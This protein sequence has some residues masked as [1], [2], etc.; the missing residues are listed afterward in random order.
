MRRMAVPVTTRVLARGDLDKIVAQLREIGA[1]YVFIGKGSV[2]MDPEKRKEELELLIKSCDY[3]KKEGF[4]VG[5]WLWS[6]L[7]PGDLPYQRMVGLN[8]VVSKNEVCPL[9]EEFLK[10]YAGYIKDIAKYAKP[11]MIMFDDDFGFAHEDEAKIECICP[12]HLKMMS[13]IAGEEITPEG[14]EKKMFAGKAN[15][16]RAAYTQAVRQTLIAFADRMRKEIDEVD[17]TI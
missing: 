4:K 14:I 1:Q 3:L 15:K 6:F 7:I 16:Y 11:D 10:Y 2:F 5:I 9:D 13:E 8:G 12:A 17:K